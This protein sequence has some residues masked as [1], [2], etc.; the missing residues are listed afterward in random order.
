MCRKN[1]FVLFFIFF[2]SSVVLAASAR[3]VKIE[4]TEVKNE[5]LYIAGENE[6]FT[7]IVQKFYEDGNLE[8]ESEFKEG[9]LDG[10]S[11]SYYK[12]TKLEMEGSYTEGRKNGVFKEYY[13]NGKI[14]SEINY[15][16]D[17]KEGLA[18]T[19]YSNGNVEAE[20]NFENGEEIGT[21]RVY[22]E[23]GKLKEEIPYT[24]GVIN[25]HHIQYSKN[26]KV[27]KKTFYDN[28]VEYK[29][30]PTETIVLIIAVIII[31]ILIVIKIVRTLPSFKLLED[32]Q[33]E[34]ILKKFIE[35]DNGDEN[36]YSSYRLNGCGTGFYTVR[37]FTVYNEKIKVLAKMI[38]VFFIPIPF[39]LGYLVCYDN[40]KIIC[41]ISKEHFNI[42]KK[43]IKEQL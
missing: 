42:L 9:I 41:S 39:A 5:V 8:I 4:Q 36:L 35:Y 6:P 43:E 29:G 30:I 23:N 12:N 10:V 27:L 28:G 38:S 34:W 33:K 2:I 40:K 15:S 24:N 1:L 17:L 18:K 21:T 14:K 16:Y 22:Y 25:G 37:T 19:Y 26:G 20:G 32:Y 3:N 31:V 7:G 11:K 13:E